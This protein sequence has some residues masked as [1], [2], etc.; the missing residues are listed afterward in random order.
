MFKAPRILSCTAGACILRNCDSLS[1][2]TAKN[3]Q[4]NLKLL[5]QFRGEVMVNA[6]DSEMIT[7]TDI[8]K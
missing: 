4:C 5:F 7:C 6:G 3:L 1:N 8:S 2:C